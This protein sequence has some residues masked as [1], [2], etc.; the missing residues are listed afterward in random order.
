MASAR[1]TA[2]R[3]RLTLRFSE[4]KRIDPRIGARQIAL[5]LEKHRIER[6]LCDVW[7]DLHQI[8]NQTKNVRYGNWAQR[9]QWHA[10]IQKCLYL[11]GGIEIGP[12]PVH[13][14]RMQ[15]DLKK[16]DDCLSQ[17]QVP[18][19]RVLIHRVME[20]IRC[21]KARRIL[22]N[23]ILEIDLVVRYR[24]SISPAAQQTINNKLLDFSKR[25]RAIDDTGFKKPVREPVE[26]SLIQA[27]QV[28][29]QGHLREVKTLCRAAARRL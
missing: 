20:S 10:T 25:L 29:T 18:Q 27:R 17:H 8:Y 2:A 4:I 13:I 9:G 24:Q 12:F 5:L 3:N 28:L 6:T 16:T 7:H 23:L 19:V 15:T 21:K 1:L 11:L 26:Q 22:E 14:Q